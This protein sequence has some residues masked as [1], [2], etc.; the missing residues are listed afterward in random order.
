MPTLRS[1]VRVTWLLMALAVA[2]GAVA[3]AQEMPDPK[4][5]SGIPR[6]VTDLPDG[7][8]SV[9][10]IKG[11]LA[12]NIAGHPV[13]LFVDG[14]AQTVNT[15]DQG[16]AQFD[17]LP[18][19][20]TLRAV[21]VV[22]G[23]RLESQEFPA[24]SAGAIRLMLVATDPDLERRKAADAAAASA[25]AVP[26]IVVIAGES[27]IV[28][29][30]G[31]ASLAVYYILDIMNTARTPVSPSAPFVFDMPEGMVGTTVIPG[32]SPLATGNGR[33][34]TVS[35]PFP[36]GKTSIEI[37]GSIPVTS[38]TVQ[39]T[40]VFPATFEQPVLIAKKDG[41]LTVVSP[42][43]DRL[44]ETA[45]EGT[46]VIIGAGNTV[47]AGQPVSVT[48]SGLAYHSNAPRLV[49]LW[50]ALAIVVVGL[51]F[52]FKPVDTESKISEQR[53]LTG[54]R[55]KLLQELARLE[56]DHRRGKIDAV[57]FRPRREELVSA[58]EA[59]YGAL[60]SDDV[61]G[62]TPPLKARRAGAS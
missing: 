35:G 49:A 3:H 15:D 11:D 56:Q 40:Q 53:K 18:A 55:E 33:Q 23:E 28:I 26:G 14:K 54:K 38:D 59:V 62:V 22:D 39:F 24:P 30:P 46:P 32:S 58:L 13:E 21:A 41:A 29:E 48:I 2:A 19:G 7:S 25:P 43:F 45:V 42:Q 34:I 52:A 37:G 57:H 27:R 31:E 47:A 44:Q 16:R 5:M 8:L 60:D 10:L 9:R 1:L 20:A 12:N 51:V 61:D 50:M 4:Q 17:K 6:P 36:P